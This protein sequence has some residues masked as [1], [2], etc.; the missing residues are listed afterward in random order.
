MTSYH[1]FGND[2][3]RSRADDG[4]KPMSAVERFL[5]GED[6]EPSAELLTAMRIEFAA[7]ESYRTQLVELLSKT[8]RELVEH[9]D[10]LANAIEVPSRDSEQYAAGFAQG[11][12]REASDN[13]QRLQDCLNRVTAAA[14][15][16]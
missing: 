10:R 14:S 12:Y 5:R 1:L 11:R 6:V 7:Q 2:S 15:K 8:V 13:A 16:A 3:E 9:S 4:G